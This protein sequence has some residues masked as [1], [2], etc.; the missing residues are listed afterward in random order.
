MAVVWL[1]AGLGML[2][3]GGEL[4]VRGA[5]GLARVVGLSPLVIGLTVVAFGTSAPELGVS[6]GAALADKPGLALAN[7]AGSNAFNILVILG[8][9]ALVAP[10]AVQ[11]QLVRLDVPVMLGSSLAL[12]LL[13]LNGTIERWEGAALFLMALLY[14]AWLIRAG[15]RESLAGGSRAPWGWTQ[16]GMAVLWIAIGLASLVLG[17]DWTVQGASAL[18]ERLGITPRI[19][20]LTIV[21]A[22]T[23]LPELATSIVAT[24]RG[25]RDMAVGNVVGSNIFNVLVILGL[26][27][28]AAP[29]GLA[30]AEPILRVDL[31]M[32]LLVAVLCLPVFILQRTISR[33]VGLF[34]LVVYGSYLG[35]VLIG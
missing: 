12:L 9:S 17:S 35:W 16:A 5:S 28:A 1:V 23:S 18:A 26:S 14:T 34:F 31:P 19:I 11:S 21:A 27:A 6:L 10:L 3:V 7:V 20:G 32:V 25:E 30:V 24:L 15:L 8:L 22:G 13:A 4:F 2:L 29:N 33:P